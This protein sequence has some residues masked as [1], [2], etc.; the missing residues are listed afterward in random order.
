[1]NSSNTRTNPSMLLR[2]STSEGIVILDQFL[3]KIGRAYFSVRSIISRDACDLLSVESYMD[4]LE[5]F[6]EAEKL[7]S[8]IM[9]ISFTSSFSGFFFSSGLDGSTAVVFLVS[10]AC[11]TVFLELSSILVTTVFYAGFSSFMGSFS[12]QTKFLSILRNDYFVYYMA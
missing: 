1:M 9:P 12:A 4:K 11:T 3:L 5:S 2:S 6:F 10:G 8:S 7:K